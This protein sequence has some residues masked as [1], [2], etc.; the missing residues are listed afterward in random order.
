MLP[1]GIVMVCLGST[2]LLWGND[3]PDYRGPTGQGLVAGG[4]YPLRWSPTENIAWKQDIPGK[5][6]SSPVV[7]AGRVFL[8]TA[9]PAE[10]KAGSDQS[11]RAL[12]LDAAT[13]KI[14]W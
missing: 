9:V 14:L 3:W 11:L 13:G 1:V 7:Y 4:S 6:W 12:C 8:T 2:P 10:N 5:G